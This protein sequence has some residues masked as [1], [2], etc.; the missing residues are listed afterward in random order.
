MRTGT[1]GL[2]QSALPED[3]L[4]VYPGGIQL[5]DGGFPLYTIGADANFAAPASGFGRHL[6]GAGQCRFRFVSA[7]TAWRRLAR[8]RVVSH[9]L[10]LAGLISLLIAGVYLRRTNN[11]KRFSPIR[12]SSAWAS[13]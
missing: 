11:Y 8:L 4:P 1:D 7:S 13:P 2:G 5:Q 12:R 6:D 10:I 3:S 9:V